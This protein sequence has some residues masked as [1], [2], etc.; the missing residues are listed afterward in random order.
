MTILIAA[1]R[2]PVSG[3]DT[4]Q[5]RPG[6]GGL[7]SL[8]TRAA[9]A[10]EREDLIWVGAAITGTENRL[11][12]ETVSTL[13]PY[14]VRFLEIPPDIYN[15]YYNVVSNRL[16]WFVHHR[17]FDELDVP[18]MDDEALDAWH[19]AYAIANRRFAELLA[20]IAGAQDLV[21]VQDY[22]LSLAPSHLRRLAPDLPIAHFTHT[23][24]ARPA[25]LDRLPDEIGRALCAGMLGADLLGFHSPRWS[26]AFLDCCAHLRHRVDRASGLVLD[27]ERRI[28]V[29]EYPAPIDV[30]DLLDMAAR[31][32][33]RAWAERLAPDGHLLVVRTDRID[34]SKNIV[35]GFEAFGQLLDRRPDLRS[36]VRFVASLFPSRTDVSEYR[37]YADRVAAAMGAVNDRHPGAIETFWDEDRDRSIGAMRIYD[38]LLVNPLLDGMN[39]VSKEGPAVNQRDGVLVL[40]REAGSAAELGDAALLVDPLD[41]HA[42][43]AALEAALDMTAGERRRRAATLRAAVGRRSP[44]DWLREQVEDLRAIASGGEPRTPPSG[45]T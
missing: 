17:L 33:A 40:S 15:G 27:G 12:P 4:G 28:W 31:D 7:V 19:H 35:R 22:H 3:V 36:R 8:L 5:V 2:A 34:P 24:F 20:A 39:V 45:V 10:F 18:V 23:P 32:P 14:G 41:V 21:L 30:P 26:S 1:N 37:Q 9:E 13:L 43:A 25:D 38:V 44:L 29:R 16:L 42:T 11:V 6:Q